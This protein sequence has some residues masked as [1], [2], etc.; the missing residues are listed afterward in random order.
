MSS[1][2]EGED[3]STEKCSRGY[4]IAACAA[5]AVR[6]DS[7]FGDGESAAWKDYVVLGRMIFILNVNY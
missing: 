2:V 4:G 7:A 3:G 6:G 1:G 5:I